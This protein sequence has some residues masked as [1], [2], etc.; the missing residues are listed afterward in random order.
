MTI[1][2]FD[3]KLNGVDVSTLGFAL[4]RLPDNWNAPVE[5]F[6]EVQI[7]G[8][9]GST[10]TALEPMVE[11]RD[12]VLEFENVQSTEQNHEDKLDAF[13]LLTRGD[14]TVIVGNQETRQR[15]GYRKSLVPTPKVGGGVTNSDVVLTLHCEDPVMYATTVR[16][17]TGAAATDLALPQGTYRTF[18]VV[19]VTSATDPFT[20]TYKH[21]DGTPLKSITIAAVGTVVVD[22]LNRT[23]TVNGVRNDGAKTGGDYFAFDAKDG[24]PTLSH[25]PTLRTSVGSLSAGGGGIVYREGYQ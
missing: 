24:D 14:V 10:R 16:T 3:V 2:S 7:P 12:Y 25:W 17:V 11:P 1:W 23:I 22:M 8:R 13:K 5:T 6:P 9:N 19:T 15:T 18:G 21:Y 20:L 4:T